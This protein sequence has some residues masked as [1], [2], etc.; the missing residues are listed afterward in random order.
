MAAYATPFHAMTMHTSAPRSI[1]IHQNG[2]NMPKA[3]STASPV[4]C[5]GVGNGACHNG[6]RHSAIA[7]LRKPQL[8]GLAATTRYGVASTTRLLQ[9]C[10][11]YMQ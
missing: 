11:E 6:D 7:K 2:Y 10:K 3:S 5:P 4:V 8:P 9:C 1:Q